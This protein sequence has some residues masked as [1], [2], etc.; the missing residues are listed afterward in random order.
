MAGM[1]QVLIDR[2]SHATINLRHAILSGVAVIAFAWV[3]SPALASDESAAR[4]NVVLIMTADQ[5]YGDVAAHGNPWIKMPHLDHLASRSICL[6]DCH[7][8]P[9]CVPTRAALLTGRHADRTGIHNVLEPHWFVRMGEMMPRNMF[10]DAEYA[11]G[12]FDKWY[13]AGNY[14]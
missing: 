14:P 7:V 4:P 12:M 11:T 10:Q 1:A 13:L 8:L 3:V 6:D 9:Y 5:G 2:V